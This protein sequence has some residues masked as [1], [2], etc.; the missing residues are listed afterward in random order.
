MQSS[1]SLSVGLQHAWVP[2]LIL[3]QPASSLIMPAGMISAILYI[4]H[5]NTSTNIQARPEPEAAASLDSYFGTVRPEPP[6]TC[7][8]PL[9]ACRVL[10]TPP[11]HRP[12][13]KQ[14]AGMASSQ[15]HLQDV[16]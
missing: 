7:I 3:Q 9:P 12:A 15:Q 8:Q 6:P 16:P 10:H 13:C 11:H 2:R 5:P 1:H 14:A 4:S